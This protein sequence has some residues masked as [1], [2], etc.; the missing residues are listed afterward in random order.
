MSSRHFLTFSAADLDFTKKNAWLKHC[1]KEALPF[2]TIRTGRKLA[3]VELDY[4]SLP[5]PLE[6]LLTSKADEM[7]AEY[8]D[9]RATYGNKKTEFWGGGLNACFKYVAIDQAEGL[10]DALYE[11]VSEKLGLSVSPA[12]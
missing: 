6:E 8:R 12:F 9:F 3:E 10:A 2:I 1:R 4:I 5:Y 7:M 11:L